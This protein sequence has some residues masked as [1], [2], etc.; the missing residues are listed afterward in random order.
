MTTAIAKLLSMIRI[1]A[2]ADEPVSIRIN[3]TSTRAPSLRP[4]DAPCRDL[5]WNLDL[6]DLFL[7]AG[8]IV[9]FGLL[10]LRRI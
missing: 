4:L 10:V 6:L 2:G 7:L 8:S 1:Y 3:L 9:Y 5:F